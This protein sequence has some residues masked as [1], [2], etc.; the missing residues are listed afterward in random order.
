MKINKIKISGGNQQFGDKI[1]N[2][3]ELND[4]D[5]KLIELIKLEVPDLEQRK[6]LFKDLENVKSKSADASKSK[7]RL[8][9][10]LE[11]ITT[12]GGKQIGRELIE[13]GS[14]LITTIFS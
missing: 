10:F 14:E 8:A 13:S 3:K 6:I 12:E 4:V 11:N 2:N 9:K 1:Y 7:S 5:E